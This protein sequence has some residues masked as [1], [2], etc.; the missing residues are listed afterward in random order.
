MSPTPKAKMFI[1]PDQLANFLVLPP[2]TEIIS[3]YVLPDPLTLNVIT[4]VPGPHIVVDE[5]SLR[6]FL[7]LP[8]HT[9]IV[10]IVVTND[11][12][13]FTVI[14]MSATAFNE[15]YIDYGGYDPGLSFIT[16]GTNFFD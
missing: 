9:K 6:D 10:N 7:N 14:L 12:L 13:S 8:E 16:I 1:S 3:M 4:S 15:A 2:T 11:P 5:P